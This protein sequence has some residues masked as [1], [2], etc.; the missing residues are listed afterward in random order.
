[1]IPVNA[2][3]IGVQDDGWGS[4]KDAP[5]AD[6]VAA[7]LSQGT[8][9]ARK[10]PST[11]AVDANRG[12]GY[13]SGIAKE[14][15]ATADISQRV[16]VAKPAK[17]GSIIADL[18]SESSADAVSSARES[19]SCAPDMVTPGRTIGGKSSV[20][21]TPQSAEKPTDLGV[22]LLGSGVARVTSSVPV[23]V[24][25][26]SAPTGKGVAVVSVPATID[27]ANAADFS[28]EPSADAASSPRESVSCAPDMV[29]HAVG[30]N[31][32]V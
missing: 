27:Y 28:V 10:A 6:V 11:S 29:M 3:E 24:G 19:V 12:S 16:I 7:L 2:Y 9:S 32:S 26:N 14:G 21:S 13:A 25:S 30:G 18:H 22:R 8:G 15:I 23:T 5:L 4:K 31:G 17:E 20:R 1:M